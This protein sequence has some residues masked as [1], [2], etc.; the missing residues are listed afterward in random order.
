MD[1]SHICSIG[2]FRALY[3]LEIRIL[4]AFVAVMPSEQ[5]LHPFYSHA[6]FFSQVLVPPLEF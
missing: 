1:R 5:L 4:K 2:L 3:I 6:G